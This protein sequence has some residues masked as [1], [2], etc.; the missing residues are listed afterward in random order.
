[1]IVL[2]PYSKPIEYGLN[3]YNILVLILY[4]INAQKKE[5]ERQS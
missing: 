4:F 5:K 2:Y 1:M 3:K